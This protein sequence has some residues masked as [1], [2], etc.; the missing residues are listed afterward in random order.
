MLFAFLLIF[1]SGQ[2]DVVYYVFDLLYLDGRD[3]RGFPLLRRKEILKTLVENAALPGIEFSDH[4]EEQGKALF[5]IATK[6]GLEG[7]VGKGA[8][9]PYLSGSRTDSWLKFKNYRIESFHIGGFT[10]NLNQI[11][12]LLFGM[13]KDKEFILCWAYGQR[14]GQRRQW[15][16]AATET[17]GTDGLTSA[18][19][20]RPDVSTAVHWVE[21]KVT[22][23]VRFLEW[24]QDGNLTCAIRKLDNQAS[25]VVLY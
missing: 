1:I 4:V 2:V 16:T 25:T 10:G 17:E 21:P 18:F 15:R 7:T 22:C 11:E 9:S 19:K 14:S 13:F 5:E 8:D 23:R 6:R 20:N 24:T 3:L 12:S